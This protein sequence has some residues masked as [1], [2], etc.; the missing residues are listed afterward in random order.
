MGWHELGRNFVLRQAAASAFAVVHS[1]IAALTKRIFTHR[2]ARVVGYVIDVWREKALVLLMH[3][4]G[5]VG[6]PEKGL[7]ERRVIIGAHLQFKQ[8][9]ARMQANAVHPF[10]ASHRIMVA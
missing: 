5:D 7:R 6:P 1:V 9:T 3:P 8:C 2:T 10:H 4:R